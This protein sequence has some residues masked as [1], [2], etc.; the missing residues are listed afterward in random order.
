MQSKL[1][2]KRHLLLVYKRLFF[3]FVNYD[4]CHRMKCNVYWFDHKYNNILTIYFDAFVP[5]MWL[6][7]VIIFMFY[8]GVIVWL[9]DTH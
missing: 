6:L 1:A 5:S 3:F 2:L 4:D 9:C 8:V 7:I